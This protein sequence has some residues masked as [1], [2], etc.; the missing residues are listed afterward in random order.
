MLDKICRTSNW[1]LNKR[2]CRTH[3]VCDMCLLECLLCYVMLHWTYHIAKKRSRCEHHWNVNES[4]LRLKLD[5]INKIYW[6]CSFLSKCHPNLQ[7]QYKTTHGACSKPHEIY[8]FQI[9]LS[10]FRSK[11][12]CVRLTHLWWAQKAKSLMW[13]CCAFIIPCLN[14]V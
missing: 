10:I 5:I 2:Q 9:Q 4:R 6:G 11:C 8:W 1:T 3:H 7:S 13:C 14:V 12:I